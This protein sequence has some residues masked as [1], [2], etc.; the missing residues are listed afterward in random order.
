MKLDY[1][2]GRQPREGFFSSDFCGSPNYDFYIQDYKVLD[3]HNNSCDVIHCRNVIHHI[4]ECDL[5]KL[6]D[7]FDRLL[8]QDGT[9]IISEPRKEFHE[10]N[11]FLDLLWYRFL[12]HDDKIMIPYEYVDYKQY[13]NKFKIEKIFNEFNNEVLTLKKE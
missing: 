10:Q 4:P 2:S 7:E 11:L 12:I 1:G 3:V 6:F 13:L 9:L 5:V 8:K